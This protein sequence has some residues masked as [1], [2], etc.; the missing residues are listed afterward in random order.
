MIQISLS[1]EKHIPALANI[2]RAAS[3]VFSEHDFP[4]SLRHETI[5]E[6]ELIVAQMQGLL[7]VAV[8]HD[9]I[10]VGFATTSRVGTYLHIAEMNVLPS[11][12]RQGIG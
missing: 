4:T 1:S 7:F 3:T 6:S 5:P 2:E 9:Q 8:S 11:H 12:Q 10:P